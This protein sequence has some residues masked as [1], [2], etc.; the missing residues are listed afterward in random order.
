MVNFI[1]LGG[2][3]PLSTLHRAEGLYGWVR[4]RGYMRDSLYKSTKVYKTDKNLS[5]SIVYMKERRNLFSEM[6]IMACNF[7]LTSS[8]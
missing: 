2:G 6:Y 8:A 3:D 5:G 1:K 7:S 4:C